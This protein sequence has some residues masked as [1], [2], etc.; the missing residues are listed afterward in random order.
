MA[1]TVTID[2]IELTRYVQATFKIKTPTITVFVDPHRLTKETV[3]GEKA[4]LIL[5]THPHFDHLDPDAI[6][7][8]KKGDTVIVTNAAC[9]PKLEGK[10]RIVTIRE[11]Q[12]TDQKGLHIKAVPG[13]NQHHPRD[14]G[15]NI[16]FVFAI[17]GK[18]VFHA[19]DTGKVPEFASLGPIDIAMVPIG[20]TY[21]MDEAEAAAAI[22]NDIKPK[23]VIPMHYG[24]ATGGDPEKFKALVGGS[25]RVEV[26]EPVIKVKAGE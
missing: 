8:V 25:A 18:Q 7:V 9:A 3:G 2:G 12:S 20:G 14:Q 6:D 4:D 22:K 11:G 24:Y 1:S 5:V 15:F 26:L 17:E 23:V 10:G 16:G 21:T 13:Y 19:G